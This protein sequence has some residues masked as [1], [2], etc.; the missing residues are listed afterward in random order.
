MMTVDCKMQLKLY[1][2][3]CMQPQK[4]LILGLLED[5]AEEWGMKLN[6]KKGYGH[7]HLEYLHWYICGSP[8]PKRNTLLT[9]KLHKFSR[10]VT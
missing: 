1:M 7:D 4:D 6:A 2:T 5:W 8:P 9:S 10:N 3:P